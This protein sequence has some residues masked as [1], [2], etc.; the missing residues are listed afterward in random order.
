MRRVI[1]LFA[2]C[3]CYYEVSM[4]LLSVCWSTRCGC[5]VSDLFVNYSF[6]IGARCN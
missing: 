5:C 2:R 6:M 3:I 4:V 1:T